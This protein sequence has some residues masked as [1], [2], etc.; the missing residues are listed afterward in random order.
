MFSLGRP[1]VWQEHPLTEIHLD[2]KILGKKFGAKI[3]GG[4]FG[5]KKLVKKFGIEKILGQKNLAQKQ[6]G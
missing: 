1:W 6:I 5:A 2:K 4:K 3:L